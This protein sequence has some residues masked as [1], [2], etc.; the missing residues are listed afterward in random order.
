MSQSFKFKYDQMRE[1]NP[2]EQGVPAEN[3]SKALED[4]YLEES[5][6]RNICF[7]W[8]D[9]KR[10]FV[11]Y[12]YLVSGEYLPDEKAITLTFTSHTFIMKGVNLEGL[13][14]DIMRHLIKQ[15]VCVD[16]RYN[17]IGENERFTVNE[18]EIKR[19]QE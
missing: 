19:Q 7:V 9:G 8:R 15:V 5:H 2:T 18:I 10:M 3:Q 6:T 16:A 13:F 17:L 12:S 4:F 1:S 14:Y 11:N